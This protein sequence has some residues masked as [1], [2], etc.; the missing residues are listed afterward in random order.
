[1]GVE[2]DDCLIALSRLESAPGRLES[3]M[4][5]R[6]ICVV[7][8]YAHT[9]DALDNVLKTLRKISPQRQLICLFGCGGDRDKSKRPE[10]AAIA[11]KADRIVITSDNCRTENPSE[12]INDIKAGL[13]AE[14]RRKCIC[15]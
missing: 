7:I 3:T 14:G 2:V 8:D 15:I 12:I 10:M 11:Q 4:G 13:S 5:P 9:P 6:G 1:L